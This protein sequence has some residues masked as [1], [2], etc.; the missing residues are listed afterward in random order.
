MQL[1][2]QKCHLHLIM[3]CKQFPDYHRELESKRQQDIKN[4]IEENNKYV[5]KKIKDQL[6]Q[7][8]QQKP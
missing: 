6:L 2:V 1:Y 8:M 4:I 3:I 7:T 5:E